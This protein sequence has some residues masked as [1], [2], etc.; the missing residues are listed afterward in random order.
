MM[1]KTLGL[2]IN[3]EEL[4]G[5]PLMRQYITLHDAACKKYGKDTTVVLY[6]NGSFYEIYATH[7]TG[8]NITKLTTVLNITLT[9]KNKSI[10]E[11]N[12]NNPFMTG[13]PVASI[14]NYVKKLVNNGYTVVVY[15]QLV[16]E[17][18]PKRDLTD[19]ISIGTYINTEDDDIDV[20][21]NSIVCIYFNEEKQYGVNDA[22]LCAGIT[23]IDITTGESKLFEL[24]STLE[25]KNT[26][27]DELYRFI[28]I[29]K[30]KEYI[31]YK[32][33][34]NN[35]KYTKEHIMEY[36]NIDKN[37]YHYYEVYPEEYHKIAV[38]T[39]FLKQI[40]PNTG[41]LSV[42]EYLN[43]EMKPYA[44]ISIMLLLQYV[45]EHNQILIKNIN[46]PEIY[47]CNK[48]LILG[49]D[50]LNQLNIFENDI[51]DKTNVSFKSLFDVINN[52]SSPMGRRFL[53]N[54]LS[55]PL[56]NPKRIKDFYDAIEI[57]RKDK[58]YKAL[59]AN[60]KEICDVEKM[61][62][63][64]GMGIQHPCHFDNFI[65]SFFVIKNITNYISSIPHMTTL[66]SEYIS[67]LSIND[68]EFGD[69]VT[70]V[71]SIFNMDELKKYK[72]NDIQNNIFKKGFSKDIDNY[73]SIVD[74]NVNLVSKIVRTFEDNIGSERK[75]NPNM[76]IQ[77]IH[78]DKSGYHMKT[79]K[80]RSNSLKTNLS[81]I[82]SGMLVVDANVSIPIN[83][84]KFE[85]FESGIKITFD[86]LDK[87]SV[88]IDTNKA[89]VKQML[90]MEYQKMLENIY[91]KHCEKIKQL[92]K[93]LSLLDYLVSGAIT[94]DKYNY[95][96]PNIV[97]D[98][99]K[100]YVKCTQ[101][102]HPLVERIKTDTPYVP[103]D[104]TLGTKLD[105]ETV[106]QDGMLLNSPNYCGKCFS[107]DTQIML[108]DGTFI[109]AQYVKEN[110]VLMGDDSGPRVV[111]GTTVG[112]DTMYRIQPTKKYFKNKTFVCNGPHI[113]C[114]KHVDTKQI[115][116]ISMEEYV[117][118]S[119]IYE[120]KY[121]LYKTCVEFDK[122]DVNDPYDYGF[123]LWK[124]N[125]IDYDYLYNS[126]DVRKQV[127]A[128]LFDSIGLDRTINVLLASKNI[129]FVND[130][131]YLLESVGYE[132]DVDG[133]MI[134]I[135][136]SISD[137][138]YN[139]SNFS[140]T[141]LNDGK[142]CGFEVDGNSRF[143]LSS[144]IV[145][146]N[147]TLMKSIGCNLI[148]A[149]CGLYTAAVNFTYSPY[150]MM[151]ARIT[152]NDNIFKGQSSFT[153]EMM[154]LGTILK[155]TGKK[156]IVIGDEVCRGTESIS[157]NS[158]VAATIITLAKT[159]TSFIFAT[160][161]HD[162][163]DMPKI[164]ELSNVQT[165]H[166]TL[167]F[168][169]VKN[170]LVFS[171]K[172]V[173]G[174]GEK[175]YGI[176]IAQ[177]IIQDKDFMKLANEI[178]NEQL[179]ESDYILNTKT[180]KY[181]NK[182]FINNCEICNKKVRDVKGEYD[183]HHINFQKDCKDGFVIDKPHMQMNAKYNLIVLCK[184]CHDNVHHGKLNINGYLE[185]SNGKVID[186]SVVEKEQPK[187]IAIDNDEEP[188][189]TVKSERGRK[190]KV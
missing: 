44:V 128:G 101:L 112:Y 96:K 57:L 119:E 152:G 113:L 183:T 86:Y 151:F 29:H 91:S 118:N 137:K 82:K 1:Q 100:G 24:Y 78:T 83:T 47:D 84:I 138:C 97:D 22:L 143:L 27:L 32:K 58:Y 134:N 6:Q 165:Y 15:S 90:K 107:P 126:L 26:T 146:H 10:Q 188:I 122:Q 105:G 177:H 106:A 140:V 67:P 150:Y 9:R 129:W 130:L 166:L 80:L 48:Y 52:T 43:I 51:Q 124:A 37:I 30:P 87:L 72:L 162:I 127:L 179:N 41:I 45:K 190:K 145:T 95:C 155:N 68:L 76:K 65:S 34:I 187:I 103:H 131:A 182:V 171:R 77:L 21:T 69:L 18:K 20:A 11:I 50:A 59:A 70:Y 114:L 36:L 149:Q 7:T 154:E 160:H 92:I 153:L 62:R 71:T 158:I 175:I 116:E 23:L 156:T 132:I 64:I 75:K 141:V 125:K 104:I 121:M 117:H 172:L 167:D 73:Q 53:K 66:F 173:K 109:E 147:S 185:T 14:N 181:N 2:N 148:M 12:E 13:F 94:S 33:P 189:V 81:F 99:E 108:H 54:M 164:K 17:K 56:T 85:D 133:K 79:S 55:N 102:R 38:Q 168:D 159:E 46:V 40:Y 169:E 42:L 180:S 184:E 93:L 136:Y 35:P 8:P 74:Y 98:T 31:I 88:I 16:N 170:I 19:V 144:F 135:N 3:N 89:I 163:P 176:K 60:L 115:L 4:Q 61:W 120:N 174:K 63:K 186:Y 178:K 157:G 28:S 139:M 123:N 111:L 5:Q 25:N 110:D 142:Y 49:N 161:L 39:A